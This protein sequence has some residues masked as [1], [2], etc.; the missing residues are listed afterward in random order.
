MSDPSPTS[1]EAAPGAVSRRVVTADGTSLRI[2]ERPGGDK[3]PFLLV[4]GLASNARLW[5][6]VGARL[7]AA[8]HPSVAVDQRGHGESDKVDHGFD[9]D[10]LVTDLEAVIRTTLGHP[11]I[12]AGQSWGGN[13]VLELAAERPDL[14][15]GVVCVDGG[16]IKL[17]EGFADWSSVERQLAPPRLSGMPVRDLEAGMRARLT[18]FPSA[19]IDAQLANF[20]VLDD[21]TVRQRLTFDR[22]MTILRFLWE[23][24]PDELA[25]RVRQP[26]MVIAARG[27]G[28]GHADRME[29]FTGRLTRGSVVWMD[30]HH[31]M[32]AERP[33]DI[34]DLL[35]GFA[36]QV[37]TET[38]GG[39]A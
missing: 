36:P 24:E 10:T 9:F 27:G 7:A 3:I 19:A 21:G 22:H 16:F 17:S 15:A 4:H 20:E 39:A 14:V 5:D 34:G 35:V 37:A 31:D 32:H 8:G 25:G 26:V 1:Q 13:V 12:V 38:E 11:V 29:S 6:G 2:I 28:L 30:A 23:H 33:E 18:S